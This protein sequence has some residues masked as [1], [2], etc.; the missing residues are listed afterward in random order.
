MWFC[1]PPCLL[2]LCCSHFCYLFGLA[3]G[4]VV[5]GG[6]DT[7]LHYKPIAKFLEECRDCE[8]ESVQDGLPLETDSRS[9]S[10]S[11]VPAEPSMSPTDMEITPTNSQPVAV[12]STSCS[13]EV[14]R[15]CCCSLLIG[16]VVVSWLCMYFVHLGPP[17]KHHGG[18]STGV[19]YQLALKLP[20]GT[21]GP[22]VLPTSA[23]CMPSPQYHGQWQT[24]CGTEPAMQSIF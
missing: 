12:R 16:E 17:R 15:A 20:K 10:L 13:P 9:L 8:H 21:H 3:G 24:R 2:K 22:A 4:L 14:C 6:Q 5:C 1:N 23:S 11:A 7:K 18:N 19:Q